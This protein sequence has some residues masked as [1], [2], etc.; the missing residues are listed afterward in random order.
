[1][2]QE[3]QQETQSRSSTPSPGLLINLV[4]LGVRTGRAVAVLFAPPA[5]AVFIAIGVLILL[6]LAVFLLG[7]APGAPGVPEVPGTTPI[8]Q[9]TL[10][11][12]VASDCPVPGGTITTHS[13]QIDPSN[14][15]CSSGYGTQYCKQCT[16]GDFSQSRRAKAIDI[17]LNTWDVHLPTINGKSINWELVVGGINYPIDRPDGGG[18]GYLFRTSLEG[19]TWFLD[20][21]HMDLITASPN[22]NGKYPS[23]TKIG[24]YYDNRSYNP[25]HIPHLH[26]TLGEDIE[27]NNTPLVPSNDKFDCSPG[28]QATDFICQ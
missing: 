14:G 9:P 17:S 3:R 16:P 28:W 4:K 26:F 10:P 21:V 24:K 19:H 22:Q 11:P 5:G 13:I 25:S 7:F 12:G 2:P 6:F 27:S 1:M 18:Y 23:G 20:L 8:L 15:H